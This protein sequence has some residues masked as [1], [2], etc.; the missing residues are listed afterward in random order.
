MHIGII[1]NDLPPARGGMQEH[2]RELMICLAAEHQVLIC[3]TRLTDMAVANVQIAPMMS[4]VL[5][6]D[7]KQLNRCPVDI[8]ITL[9]A[10][11][12]SYAQWL[13]K[14]TFA[15]VHGN[16]L[17]HP[18]QPNPTLPIRA[19]RWA[20]HWAGK[21]DLEGPVVAWRRKKVRQGL[22]ATRGTFSNSHFTKSLCSQM[23][24]L[25]E[26][27]ITVVHPGISNK[28]YQPHHAR[29]SSVLRL[30]TV[31]RLDV[32]ASRKNITGVL[33]AIA[34]LKG[35]IDIRYSV[36]GTGNDKARLIA[37]ARYLAVEDSVDFLGDLSGEEIAAVLSSNDLFAMVVRPSETDVEGFGMVYAEAAA[38]G[39]PSIAT[40]TG[41]IP[42][43]VIDGVTG[44]LLND[45]SPGGIADGL[46]RFRRDQERFDQNT[47]RTFAEG[48]S[49][50]SCTRRMMDTIEALL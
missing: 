46:R 40:A 19:R 17:I 35:E 21:V 28:Y 37:L 26:D 27:R 33:E 11:L 45:I 31:S 7:V 32:G 47:L 49:A 22:H 23:Y 44:I 25:S 50:A 8:W 30:V 14:P 48:F 42:D 43:A 24:K 39:L 12:A 18:W 13:A 9:S 36:I 41:G 6:D 38:S 4:G 34:L 20:Q 2:A 15:Y 10:G 16:D 3:S 5:S 1:T 29:M